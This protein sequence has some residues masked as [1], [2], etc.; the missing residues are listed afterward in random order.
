MTKS[1]NVAQLKANLSRYLR[2][3]RRG[4]RV[5]VRDRNTPIAEIRRLGLPASPI[6]RLAAEGKVVPATKTLAQVK[7]SRVR[8]PVDVQTSLTDIRESNE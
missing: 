7:I 3:A 5:V 6:E 4:T 1:V 2:E 8:K